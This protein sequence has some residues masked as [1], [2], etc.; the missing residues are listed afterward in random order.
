MGLVQ[1]AM[2]A[3]IAFC[4]S[5]SLFGGLLAFVANSQ[6]FFLWIVVGVIATI[7]HVPRRDGILAVT[8]KRNPY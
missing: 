3:G 2:I 7:L 1:T 6:Y 4:E 8:F 5:A